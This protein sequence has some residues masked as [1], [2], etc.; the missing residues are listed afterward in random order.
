MMMVVMMVVGVV[1]RSD[2]KRTT[3]R[4]RRSSSGQRRSGLTSSREVTSGALT[5]TRRPVEPYQAGSPADSLAITEPSSPSWRPSRYLHPSPCHLW[6]TT[7]QVRATHHRVEG[8]RPHVSMS[9]G[10]GR[11]WRVGRMSAVRFPAG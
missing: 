4:T 7:L 11:T 8:S 2:G 9:G 1:R 6:G 10:W 5:T 3:G